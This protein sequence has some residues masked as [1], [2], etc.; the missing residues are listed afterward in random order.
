[1]KRRLTEDDVLA[2]V[3][4]GAILGGGGGGFTADG[5]RAA[6]LALSLGVPELWSA[7]EFAA[8]AGTATVALVGAP[9]ALEMHLSPEHLAR[10]IEVLRGEMSQAMRLACLHTNES[11]AQ[12]TVNGWIQAAMTGLPVLDLACNGRAH[13]SS[14]MGAMG[15]H[16][17]ADYVSI[18]AYAG[19]AEARYLE[20]LTRGRLEQTSAL[21]RHA[22]V[23]AGGGVAVARNPVSVGYAARHGAPGAISQAIELG[24]LVLGSGID[25]AVRHLDGRIVA[26]GVVQSYRCERREGLDVGVVALDDAQGTEI[27]FI[28]EYMLVEQRGRRIAAFPELITTLDASGAPVASADVREGAR[29]RVLCVPRA[30][31]LLSRTMFMPE[32]Y[33]PLEA[34]LGRPFAPP[35]MSS[36]PTP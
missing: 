8:D 31:L 34:T 3:H 1:M 29:L 12:T 11:G 32:L 6:R 13:P 14:V 10:T 22:S 19:G 18:Q 25:A 17:D 20:G 7:D 4:G 35:A 21:V 2:A 33:Q 24:R 26:E 16:T 15:L 5:I 36:G 9:S 27:P 30:R 28:N 23:L